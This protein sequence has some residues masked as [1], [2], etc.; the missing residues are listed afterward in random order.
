[1]R[2]DKLL[3]AL[4]LTACLAQAGAQNVEIEI[5]TRKKGAEIAPTMYGV[6]FEDINYG[7]DGG[8]YAEL[9]KNRSF[10]FP[11][12]LM[13]WNSIG[14]VEVR[15]DGPFGRCPHYVRLS[16]S[17]KR[18]MS[19]G[20]ENRGFLGMS[21]K[22]GEAYRFSV[23]ARV[24]GEGSGQLRVCLR[25]LETQEEDFT[26]CASD[27][28][29]DGNQW[30]KYTAVF[31]PEHTVT[32]ASLAVF[33]KGNVAVD[34][35]HVSLFPTKT[36]RGHENGLRQDLAQHLAELKPGVMR[37]PGGCIVEGAT[38][39]TRYNWKNSVGAVENRP[40]NE[41]R[42]NYGKERT[43]FDYYQSYGLGFF[44]FFQFCEEIGAE[45]LPVLSCGM[46][47]QFN[48]DISKK[49]EWIAQGDSLQEFIQDA[50]D[51]IEFCNGD[52]EKN[53][54]ARLRA[55]MGHPAPFN[56]K[57][58]GIGNEQWGE[59]YAP[60]L[61]AFMKPIR[62]RYPGI[63]IVG[64][65]GPWP[66]GKE[67]D[68]L[69][70]LMRKAKV[71]YVDEH[72]YKD[73]EFFLT[74][75]NRYDKFPRKG[76]KVYA[77]EYACHG[78]G[79]KWNRFYSSL[80]EAAFITGLERNADIV[81]MA[82]YAPLFAHIDGWQWRPD[83]I[84]FDNLRSVRTASYYVQ[85]MFS[86]NRGTHVLPVTAKGGTDHVYATAARDAADHD[87]VVVKFVNIGDTATQVSIRLKGINGECSMTTTL[88]S[89]SGSCP[90]GNVNYGPDKINSLLD[91]D[92][93]LDNPTRIVPETSWTRVTCPD[94]TA[95]IPPRSVAVFR[96]RA[97]E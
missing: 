27:I 65:S 13:G 68:E 88:L 46:A 3:L 35:E 90:L 78:R 66:N 63:E 76:P 59:W 73:E 19:T 44:E 49:G 24:P 97:A 32:N 67:Y 26:L 75:V 96:I 84:W 93:S 51:L 1:M 23:W 42:W 18:D 91:C 92:N 52:P 28:S 5:D 17:G 62:Q 16:F 61:Q 85:Q 2:T 33:L 82:T 9:V 55:E 7:A 39:D 86:Q 38:L 80:C 81:R 37:F 29:I 71:D 69:W 60:L 10:E 83:M 14:G 48:N 34:V 8:L 56:L 77:G 72:F 12:P 20:I 41:T 4:C 25:D 22:G 21:L 64:S 79:K 36:W 6:F 58:L 54:W 43:H 11:D 30:R 70:P 87:A 94:V 31:T 57:F 74:A 40:L 89:V 45:P 53:Q 95:N 50:I 15:D 47:C